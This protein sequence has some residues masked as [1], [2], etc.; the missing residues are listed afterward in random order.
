MTRA[1]GITLQI[2]VVAIFVSALFFFGM[3]VSRAEAMLYTNSYEAMPVSAPRQNLDAGIVR[4]PP[5]EGDQID[6]L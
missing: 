1:S 6:E 5:C 4:R 3:A 2:L